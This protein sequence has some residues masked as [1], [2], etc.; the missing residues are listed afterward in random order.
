[1]FDYLLSGFNVFLAFTLKN[2]ES[3][4]KIVLIFLAIILSV[5]RIYSLV[6]KEFFNKQK[7]KEN[8][9]GK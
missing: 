1:M 7:G 6:K 5:I 8:N 3:E 9:E 4:L 2:I